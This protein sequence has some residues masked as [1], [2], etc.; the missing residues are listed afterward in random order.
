MTAAPDTWMSPREYQYAL[1]YPQEGEAQLLQYRVL[2]SQAGI[3]H[4]VSGKLHTCPSFTYRDAMSTNTCSIVSPSASFQRA[5][6]RFTKSL[7]SKQR[8]DFQAC[9]LEDVIK[10]IGA[11]QERRGNERALRGIARLQKFIE[12]MKQYG[13]LVNVFLNSTPFLGFIWV[14]QR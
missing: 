5:L 6:E 13:E 12:A 11:I 1:L 4:M 14:H 7:S 3:E 8:E 2:C 10:E 9:T